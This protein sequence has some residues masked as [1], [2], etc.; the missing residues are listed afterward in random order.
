MVKIKA[1]ICVEKLRF[2][3]CGYDWHVSPQAECSCEPDAEFIPYNK[4]LDSAATLN[5]LCPIHCLLHYLLVPNICMC[6]EEW[7]RW[8]TRFTHLPESDSGV[9]YNFQL[10]KQKRRYYFQLCCYWACVS[11]IAEQPLRIQPLYIL[12]D[13]LPNYIILNH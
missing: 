13:K 10:N 3:H 11:G 4:P 9:L 7:Q 6:A 1:V 2:R 8:L 5:S 12:L